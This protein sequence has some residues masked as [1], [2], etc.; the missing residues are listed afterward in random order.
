MPASRLARPRSPA[1][2]SDDGPAV[3][4]PGAIQQ[5]ATMGRTI[6]LDAGHELIREGDPTRDLGIVMAG[7]LA[8]RLRVPERGQV[9][10]LTLDPGEV[11]G[12]SAVVPPHRSTSTVVALLPTDLVAVDGE[13]IRRELARDTAL[14]SAVYPLIVDALARRLGATR[15]QLLDLFAAEG[16]EPW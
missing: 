14:A 11:V 7:R 5:L 4:L 3:R 10:I 6:H 16:R 12:W 9:T 2:W 13:R 8:L 1:A 15:V